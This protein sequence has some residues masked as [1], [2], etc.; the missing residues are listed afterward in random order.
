[1]RKNKEFDM[2]KAII[3]GASSGIGRYLA[4]ILAGKG[5]AVGLV[6]RRGDALRNIQGEL[7]STTYIKAIDIRN[8][9]DTLKGLTGLI[10]EMGGVD[11]VII[12]SGIGFINPELDLD[13]ELETVA[14]NVQGFVT[15]ANVAFR[16]FIRQG[17][18]HLVG[19]SSIAAIRGGAE[20]PAY[21]AS[22]A[23]I[24]NYLQGL[25]QKAAKSKLT[26]TVT[27]V[28][29]GFVDTD[30]AKGEGIFWMAPV[31][32]AAAQIYRAIE[33][34]RSHAFVTKRWR[35]VAWMLKIMPDFLYHRI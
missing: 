13:K 24:S 14:T 19:I 28:Q 27:D 32:K 11:L 18:G 16:H 21:N 12:S 7:Q 3:V 6:A 4:K 9:G 29:P 26:I 20:A 31:Q 22:K 33:R 17:A 30:M 35:L 25:R 1:M 5:Y 10:T 8:R 34:K 23:F 2:K 15:V